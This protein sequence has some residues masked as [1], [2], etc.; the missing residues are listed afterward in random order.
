MTALEDAIFTAITNDTTLKGLLNF[1]N[2]TYALYPVVIDEDKVK[3]REYH[4]T[5][6]LASSRIDNTLDRLGDTYIFNCF[7]TTLAKARQLRNAIK[8]LFVR[9]K[10]NLGSQRDIKKT[11]LINIYYNY[12]KEA[13]LYYYSVVFRFIYM[14][15]DV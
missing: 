15:D 5:Y 13:R 10:G 7:G 2:N 9:Y 8:T 4:I 3:D 11:I 14:G 12:D 6:Q 1:G